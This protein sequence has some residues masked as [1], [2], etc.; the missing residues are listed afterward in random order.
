MPG[1]S[2]H[3]IR[4]RVKNKSERGNGIKVHSVSVLN[5]R[6]KN[7]WGLHLLSEVALLTDSKLEA[8]KVCQVGG[9]G[10]GGCSTGRKIVPLYHCQG[11]NDYL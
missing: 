9:G 11:E 7:K 5:S 8:I 1:S 4:E 3:A 10:G 6:N 2:Q